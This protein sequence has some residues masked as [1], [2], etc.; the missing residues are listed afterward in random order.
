MHAGA[1]LDGMGSM[2]SQFKKADVSGARFALIFGSAELEQNCVAIKTMR[3][4]AA[5]AKSD[6][7]PAQTLHRLD[8]VAQWV[9]NLR[10]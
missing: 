9:Q 7:A 1:S 8:D 2:K 10:C 5:D 4:L 6:A 3:G